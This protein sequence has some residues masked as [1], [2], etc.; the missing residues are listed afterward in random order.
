MHT[1]IRKRNEEKKRRKEEEKKKRKRKEVPTLFIPVMSPIAGTLPPCVSA[2]L[3]V[4][5]RA[6]RPH[7]VPSAA[8][9]TPTRGGGD[10]AHPHRGHGGGHS[11]GSDG[12]GDAVVGVVE[13]GED[14]KSGDGR[15][16][17]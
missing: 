2:V 12:D 3:R 11:A 13:D 4:C 17:R 5:R 6:H 1:L 16:T 14:G 15:G 10:T 7:A 9:T 8:H